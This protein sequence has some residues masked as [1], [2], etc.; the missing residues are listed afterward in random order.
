[1]CEPEFVSGDYDIEY[2]DRIGDELLRPE[3]DAAE[4]ERR[5]VAAAIA[6]HER[7]EAAYVVTQP[8]QAGSSESAWLLAARRA[9]LR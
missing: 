9:G 4:L 1:M 3:T 6:E 8:S 5:A 2:I 7:R